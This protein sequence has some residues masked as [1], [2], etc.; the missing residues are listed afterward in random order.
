[1]ENLMLRP[2]GSSGSHLPRTGI[3]VL[4]HELAEEMA[5]ALGNAGRRA[6]ECLGRLSAHQGAEEERAR[7]VR[8]A[9]DAVYAYF[10]QRELCGF[11]RHDDVVRSLAIPRAVLA[12]LGAR[13]GSFPAHIRP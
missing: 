11:K 10:I 4:D 1:M 9:A 5:V 8:E 12:R 6:E 7:L 3:A 13:C 2:P